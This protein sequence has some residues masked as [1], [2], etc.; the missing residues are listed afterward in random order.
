MDWSE[1]DYP[2]PSCSAHK[3]RVW[4]GMG[5]HRNPRTRRSLSDRFWSMVR[6]GSAT[7]CWRWL[8]SFRKD[9]YG[10]L[11]R[12]GRAG[13]VAAHRVSFHL[14]TG[15]E[16]DGAHYVLHRC[17]NRWCVNPAHLF[18]GTQA[19]NIADMHNKRRGAYGFALP[20][21]KLSEAD[22]RAIRGSS[23]T[24]ASLARRYGVNASNISRIR[25]GERRRRVQ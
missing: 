16:L 10:Q 14:H 1:S 18:S 15:A 4:V 24:V 20:Q 22:V 17:D 2:V 3:S 11:N 13:A 23:E 5:K 6:R 8:G 19:D 21:T 12:G 7:G 9:G 25:S